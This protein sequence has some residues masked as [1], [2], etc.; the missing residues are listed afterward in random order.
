VFDISESHIIEQGEA[1]ELSG[2][3]EQPQVRITR[4]QTEP[5]LIVDGVDS[6]EIFHESSNRFRIEYWGYMSGRLW[7]TRDGV[8]ELKQSFLDDQEE[9]PGWTLTTE[10]AEL[11][12]W[13]PAPE[14][15]PSPVICYECGSEVSVTEVV[16]P[17]S[18]ETKDRYCPDCWSSVRD[19]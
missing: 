7:L 13:F 18:E 1:G 10:L 5:N 17:W 9:I 11:P 15:P 14:S 12:D 4:N 6:I 16:T 3:D 19:L 2:S 8:S